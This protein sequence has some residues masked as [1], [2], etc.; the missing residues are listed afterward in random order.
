MGPARLVAQLILLVL[1]VLLVLLQ[2][3]AAEGA[4][5]EPL[6]EQ[7]GARAGQKELEERDFRLRSDQGP[8]H[9]S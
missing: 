1:L 8:P 7:P 5:P 6:V 9:G 3:L 4:E 2:A